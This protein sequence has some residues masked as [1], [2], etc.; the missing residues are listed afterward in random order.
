MIKNYLKTA[1]RNIA[2]NKLFTFLN[3]FGLSLGMATA[4]LIYF[5]VQDELS[6][7]RHFENHENIY[8]VIGDYHMN[9]LDFN[10]ASVPPTMAAAL[11]N[12]YPEVLNTCRFRSYGSKLITIGDKKYEEQNAIYA[13]STF[14]EIFNISLI[15]GNPD[16]LLNKAEYVVI[17]ETLAE[18]YF[19]KEN[20]V[21]KTIIIESDPYVITGIFENIPHNTHFDFDIILAMSGLEESFDPTW[22]ANNFQ[23]YMVLHPETDLKN[24]EERFQEMI[25]KYV[26]PGYPEND[27]QNPG[28]IYGRCRC[29]L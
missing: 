24:L 12:D 4:I 14:F 20:A 1:I 21:G 22:L 11:R 27:G 13:D 8:R 6:Y 2:R 28:G 17:N 7:D 26:G 3:I 16:Q 23:T 5:W 10:V 29:F 19:E 18:K 25:I 15:S 9:G